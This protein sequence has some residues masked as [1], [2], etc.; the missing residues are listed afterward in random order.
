MAIPPSSAVMPRRPVAPF[1]RQEQSSLESRG[2]FLL[3][4]CGLVR[5]G[6][7]FLFLA[8]SGGGK[9]TLARICRD[10]TDC[11]S[12]EHL[13]L[14]TK[15]LRLS[16]PPCCP[17]AA[18]PEGAP[19]A[20]AFLLQKTPDLVIAPVGAA[21]LLS[22]LMRELYPSSWDPEHARRLLDKAGKAARDIPAFTLGFALTTDPEALWNAIRGSTKS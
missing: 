6:R 14:D 18:F 5:N 16:A 20:T 19:L 3:H 21:E 12:D 15:R 2:T 10:Q 11:L 7:A 4:G 9:S 22:V 8:R 1:M 13:L 17:S